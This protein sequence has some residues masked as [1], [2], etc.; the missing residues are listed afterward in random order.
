[1]ALSDLPWHYNL[2]WLTMVL[3]TAKYA[4]TDEL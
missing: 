3:L 1:M 2:V 4:Q